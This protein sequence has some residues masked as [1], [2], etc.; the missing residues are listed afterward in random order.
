VLTAYADGEEATAGGQHRDPDAAHG[1]D[2]CVAPVDA[3]VG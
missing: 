2:P 1:P 3:I